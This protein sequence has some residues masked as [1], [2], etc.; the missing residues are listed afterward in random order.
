M[1]KYSLELKIQVV[2]RF[3]TGRDSALTVGDD[4]GV[5]ASMVKTWVRFYCAQGLDGLT[6]KFSHYSAEFKLSVLNHL[7]ENKHSSKELAAAFNIRSS[8][9][10]GQWERSYREGGVDALRSRPRGKTK[11][12]VPTKIPPPPPKDPNHSREEE[13]QA[14]NDYLRMENTYLKKLRALIQS[15]RKMTPAKKRK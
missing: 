1:S 13:L 12:A 11:M 9:M 3:I 15:Q 6:K 10:I 14:E 2:D 5:P 7:W 8:A 4:I